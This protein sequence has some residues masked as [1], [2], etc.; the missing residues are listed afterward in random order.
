MSDSSQRSGSGGS[1]K[2]GVEAVPS[3]E[4]MFI[5]LMAHLLGKLARR[6]LNVILLANNVRFTPCWIT[7][8]PKPHSPIDYQSLN[9]E[10]D[11][12]SPQCP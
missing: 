12:H 9:I 1:G 5:G 2:P 10:I 4:I 8:I 11:F 6:A 7:F 3:G